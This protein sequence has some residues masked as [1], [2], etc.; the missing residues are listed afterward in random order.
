[1]LATGEWDAECKRSLDDVLDHDEAAVDGLSLL[2][3]GCIHRVGIQIANQICSVAKL[4]ELARCRLK[5]NIH[6][7][8]RTAMEHMFDPIWWPQ[9]PVGRPIDPFEG[10]AKSS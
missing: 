10:N 5:E 9:D 7:T 2:T 1:M 3:L 8:V 6:I 4:R